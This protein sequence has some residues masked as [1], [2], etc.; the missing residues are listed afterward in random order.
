MKNLRG[1]CET[2]YKVAVL[3]SEKLKIASST[4]DGVNRE[5]GKGL[6]RATRPQN[7]VILQ[8]PLV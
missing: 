8:L 3:H 1:K 2:T 6:G 4:R 5:G 7:T